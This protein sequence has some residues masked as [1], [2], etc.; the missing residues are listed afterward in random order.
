M[1]M[2]VVTVVVEMLVMV[3]SVV[4]ELLVMVVVCTMNLWCLPLVYC[5]VL[6]FPHACVVCFACW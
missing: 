3:V 1:R 5:R 4:V 2:V 6:M